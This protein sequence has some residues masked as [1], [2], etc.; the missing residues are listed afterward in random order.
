MPVDFYCY[1]KEVEPVNEF[2]IIDG[3]SVQGTRCSEVCYARENA[4]WNVT[5]ECNNRKDYRFI[6]VDNNIPL[7]RKNSSG[8]EETGKSCD[9]ILYTNNTVCFIELKNERKRWL[10]NAVRQ[11]EAT[12]KDFGSLIEKYKNK[13]AYACNIQFPNS[14]CLFT[15]TQS[16]FYKRNRIVLRITTH[17]KEL[18]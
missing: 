7:T 3:F 17:I 12:I 10:Q 2:G 4:V 9:A 6:P 8:K 15:D 13:R 5:V 1:S 14:S 18:E 16:E 11:L